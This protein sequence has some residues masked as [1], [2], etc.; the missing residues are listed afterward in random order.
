MDFQHFLEIGE[1]LKLEARDLLS[2]VEKEMDKIRVREEAVAAREETALERIAFKET[3][4]RQALALREESDRQ[5]QVEER[6]MHHEKAMASMHLESDRTRAES[7]NATANDLNQSRALLPI[8]PMLPRFK[9]S[10]GNVDAYLQ[11][12]QRYAE[13]EG[14]SVDCHAIYLSALLEGPALELEVYHRLP[15]SDANNYEVVK[16]ALLRK[17]SLT[18]GDYRKNFF[19]CKQNSNENASQFFSRLEHIISQWI[20]LSKIDHSFEALRDLILR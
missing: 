16:E 17:Y 19:A 9:E 2:F 3:A 18:S 7:L 12:F 14:W 11:R 8:T 20:L 5:I 1:R 4:D 6:R 13:N 15:A 10:E